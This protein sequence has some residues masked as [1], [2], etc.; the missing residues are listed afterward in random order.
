M[1][2][3]LGLPSLWEPRR[4]RSWWGKP[5]R[6]PCLYRQIHRIAMAGFVCPRCLF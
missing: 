3:N 6:A 2:Y 5:V 4:G 1:S